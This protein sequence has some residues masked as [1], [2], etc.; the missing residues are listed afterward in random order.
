MKKNR[1]VVARG[2]IGV[3]GWMVLAAAGA[4]GVAGARASAQES[5][6]SAKVE[7][8]A[9]AEQG[10]KGGAVSVRCVSSGLGLFDIEVP[11]NAFE[12]E[13]E[14]AGEGVVELVSEKGKWRGKLHRVEDAGG[15]R[16][17]GRVVVGKD[18]WGPGSVECVV[19]DLG[20]K[21]GGERRVKQEVP[22]A[23]TP[24]FETPDWAKGAVWYQIFP[25]R[26][27]NGNPLNDPRGPA[28]FRA[29]WNSDWYAVQ[30]G[31][32]EAVE[33]RG[34]ASNRRS[35]RDR[36]HRAGPLYNVIWDRRYG[37]DLQGVVD[38]LDELKDLGVTAIYLNPIFEAKSL[39]KYDAS[40]FRHIDDRFGRPATAGRS[41]EDDGKYH[42]D[43]SETLD[44]A[45]WKW[46]AAD[47]YFVQVFIP[48]VHKRGMKVILDGVWNH[49]GR[50]FWA[51][52]HVRKYGKKSPYADWFIA[53]FDEEGKLKSW[54]GWDGKNGYLPEFQQVKGGRVPDA[55]TPVT[56]G[57][58]HPGPKQHVFDVTKRWMDPNGDGDPSDGID[59]W[60]LD[61]AGEV[62]IEFWADWFK[63]VKG[64]NPEAITVAEIWD[65]ASSLL[66]GNGFD[67]QMHYPFVYPLIDWLRGMDPEGRAVTSAGLG[68]RLLAAATKDTP[69]TSLVHQNLVAS[70]DTDRWV[71]M[72]FNSGR[73]YDRDNNVQ[74]GDDKPREQSKEDAA[75][76]KRSY[77]PYKPGKPDEDAYKRSVL[78]LVVQATFLGS[79]MVYYGDEYGMWGADDPTCRKPV[80]WEDAGKPMNPDDA[81][82]AG[83]R[84]Q[85]KKWLNLRHDPKM[86]EVLRLGGVRLRSVDRADV[87]AFERFLNDRRVLVVV[88][89]GSRNQDFDLGVLEPSL[90]GTKVGAVDAWAGLVE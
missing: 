67:T 22:T 21:D 14:L 86:G 29:E 77:V 20:G 53:D 2:L 80:P 71:N 51:F 8:G 60:R 38:K 70:H 73:G 33:A 55:L 64:I 18:S 75:A 82:V 7:Q 13:G 1:D 12:G 62:G 74:N 47:K 89:R 30:P 84:E 90:A 78:G 35:A 23:L 56:K 48:E 81:P 25:E 68:S 34:P 27:R 45:T 44:P 28:V 88:N 37:G 15:V 61:V 24:A 16:W 58:L 87:F 5:G 52:Q 26:F 3:G 41:E 46:T 50:E 63:L 76:G 19:K 83:L 4:V 42:A 17:V 10:G 85:Y 11:R 49:V 59:G 72:V 54:S 43:E 6:G 32:M 69:Q 65:S 57:D 79:P 36:T 39:H 66:K 31:E 9:K 40:D